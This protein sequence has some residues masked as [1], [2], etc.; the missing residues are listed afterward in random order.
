MSNSTAD[1]NTLV[2]NAKHTES[3][4]LAGKSL[5]G[6]L[7]IKYQ[8]E[9]RDA[10]ALI[11]LAPVAKPD[12]RY[13]QIEAPVLILHGTKDDTIPIENLREIAT[14]FPNCKLVEIADVNHGFNGKEVET[15]N[16]I[17]EW[18]KS[19]DKLSVNL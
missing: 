9:K 16:I 5:G 15:A 11:L 19:V 7:A 1:E 4:I 18:L 14:Y 17:R 10:E 8:L 12:N 3:K 13:R 2:S 6:K